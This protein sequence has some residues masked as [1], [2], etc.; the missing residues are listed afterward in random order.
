VRVRVI[1]VFELAKGDSLS[2]ECLTSVSRN[3]VDFESSSK[4]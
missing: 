2:R 3:Q 1:L 4:E